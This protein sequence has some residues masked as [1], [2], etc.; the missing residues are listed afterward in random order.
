MVSAPSKTSRSEVSYG[1][2]R[3]EVAA[4]QQEIAA[5]KK[6]VAEKHRSS[7]EGWAVNKMYM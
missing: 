2:P 3:D 4:L 1:E 5:L 6:E 7:T